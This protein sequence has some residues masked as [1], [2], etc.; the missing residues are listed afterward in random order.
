MSAHGKE[1]VT[2][3][4][5]VRVQVGLRGEPRRL[6]P[7]RTVTDLK[8]SEGVPTRRGDGRVIDVRYSSRDGVFPD[9]ETGRRVPA[10]LSDYDPR[11]RDNYNNYEGTHPLHLLTTTR[12]SVHTPYLTSYEVEW[13]VK[14]PEI[15][16]CSRIG[17]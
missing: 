2:D 11:R 3:V 10:Q 15:I 4:T 8:E 7:G 12:Q 17:E 13:R 16:I 9:K 1:V 5:R 14:V 6:V